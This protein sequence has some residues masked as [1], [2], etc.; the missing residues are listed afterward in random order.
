MG[1][2]SLFPENLLYSQRTNC[3]LL[4]KKKIKILNIIQ[5]I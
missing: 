1:Q 4:T 2:N 3:K 5:I